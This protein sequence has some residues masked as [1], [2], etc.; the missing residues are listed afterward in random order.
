[1]LARAG[2]PLLH[3]CGGRDPWLDSQTRVLEKRYQELGG[4]VTVIVQEGVGHFPT[5]PK[6]PTPVVVFIT[7]RQPAKVADP[8][9]RSYR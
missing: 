1:V 4:L 9:S 7:R 3:V 2:V 5:A 6:D 8:P